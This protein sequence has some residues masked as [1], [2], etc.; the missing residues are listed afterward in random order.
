VVVLLEGTG[1]LDDGSS[2]LAVPAVTQ[3]MQAYF[4]VEPPAEPP[5]ECPA[6]PQ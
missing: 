3:I 1:D 4:Q 6:L 2:T 5:A